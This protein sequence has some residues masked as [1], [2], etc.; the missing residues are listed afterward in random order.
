MT[1]VHLHEY[2][3]ADEAF[4]SGANLYY[5]ETQQLLRSDARVGLAFHSLPDLFQ[6]PPKVRDDDV[7][8]SSAGPY[9][10]VYHLLRERMKGRFRIVRDVQAT[11]HAGYFLQ[12]RLCAA[13]MR[14]GDLVLFPSEYCRAAYLAHFEHLDE[15]N[16]AVCYPLPP[17]PE[18]Q[19][20]TQRKTIHLG[21][22]GRVTAEKNVDQLP[23]LM[24]GLADAGMSAELSVIGQKEGNAQPPSARLSHE[25]AMRHLAGLDLLLHPSTSSL[26]SLGRVLLEAGALGVP[27]LAADHAAAPELLGRK[28]L[29]D[30]DYRPGYYPMTAAHALG[31]IDVEQWAE[32]AIRWQGSRESWPKVDVRRF[33]HD[34]TRFS[35][36]L[37]GKGKASPYHVRSQLLGRCEVH[38]DTLSASLK[39][40]ASITLRVFEKTDLRHIGQAMADICA[41]MHYKPVLRVT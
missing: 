28:A 17:V 22:L 8:L 16:T 40:A 32:R 33:A 41:R 29:L 5:Q 4:I 26:E 25:E 7:M 1:T 11:F 2:R 12:E 39:E 21:Y 3:L 13:G 27:A 9:A 15:G 14:D 34:R 19:R 31:S 36:L 6:V 18:L 38:Q 37:L 20:P 30:V 23:A 10:Y 24:R 35:E